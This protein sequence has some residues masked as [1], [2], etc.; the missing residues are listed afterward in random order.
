MCV[1]LCFYVCVC[2]YVI[3]SV[4]L[5]ALLPELKQMNNRANAHITLHSEMLAQYGLSRYRVNV[6]I[7]IVRKSSDPDESTC[8]ILRHRA[9]FSSS[10]ATTTRE[11]GGYEKFS[12]ACGI[13]PSTW[14]VLTSKPFPPHYV[15]FGGS[16]ATVCTDQ[17][18]SLQ[19]S[20]QA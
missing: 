2:F 9:K 11:Y 19:G 12:A 20:N 3:A 13:V 14:V 6:T 1:F 4:V 16:V 7:R 18:Q 17:K 15:E 8:Q 10:V 5:W